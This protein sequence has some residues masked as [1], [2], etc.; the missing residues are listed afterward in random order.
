MLDAESGN[1][2]SDSGSAGTCA[3][4]FSFEYS[5]GHVDDS[6]VHF[7]NSVGYV[8]GVGSRVSVP[9]GIES[10]GDIVTLVVFVPIEVES[11]LGQLIEII[12]RPKS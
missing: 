5:V 6:V 12:W 2:G 11:K 7:D 4:S 9:I 1:Y 10:N 3:F 8:R